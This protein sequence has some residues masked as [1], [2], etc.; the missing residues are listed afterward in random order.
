MKI[1]KSKFKVRKFSFFSSEDNFD[2]NFSHEIC[3]S[4]IYE[5]PFVLNEIDSYSKRSKLS[6]LKIHNASW[7]FRDIHIV[8]KT[9]LDIFY[10]NTTHSDLKKS[11]LLNTT[12]WD[13]TSPPSEAMR[14]C[15]DVV[16]NISRLEEVSGSH[17]QVLF[18]HIDQ[19]KIGGIFI[20]TFDVPGLQ[21][22]IIEDALSEKIVTP[23]NKLSPRNSR[24]KDLTLGLADDF[25]VGLLVI[26]RIN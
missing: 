22:E 24:L 1:D 13:I 6:N 25:G 5:Y 19:L 9:W 4:R 16:I 17:P 11:T 7:G 2:F 14:E 10:P 3:W 26:E 21:L 18:N 15:F 8:F 23:K 20:C 12:V